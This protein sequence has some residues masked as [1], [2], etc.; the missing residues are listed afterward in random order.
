VSEAV[1]VDFFQAKCQ[2]GPHVDAEFG[3]RDAEGLVA[4]VD[5]DKQ[6]EENH[7]IAT[8]KNPTQLAVMFTAV[9]G[10]VFLSNSPTQRCDVMLT[11]VNSL[12]FIELKNRKRPTVTFKEG[13]AQLAATIE[14]IQALCDVHRFKVR[15][16]HVC[17]KRKPDYR[18]HESHRDFVN[19]Y[20]FVLKT[21][22]VIHISE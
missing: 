11:T 5:K 21:E 10:C 18:S 19:S 17:N 6:N 3:I 22:T 1:A 9:D 4:Y 15:M 7:W 8:V 16:A 12:H 13:K 2:T 20:G 14:A